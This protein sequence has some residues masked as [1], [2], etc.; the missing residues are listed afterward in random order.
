MEDTLVENT[1]LFFKVT[2][3]FASPLKSDTTAVISGSDNAT[4][5]R[6]KVNNRLLLCT[7]EAQNKK[8]YM[9]LLKQSRSTFT[10]MWR[11]KLE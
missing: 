11:Q 9:E 1:Y 7:A 2:E 3:N 5:W 6:A 8:M 10:E 4:M